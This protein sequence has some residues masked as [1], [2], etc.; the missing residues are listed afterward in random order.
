MKQA[1]NKHIRYLDDT[2]SFSSKHW[3]KFIFVSNYPITILKKNAFWYLP[4]VIW[5]LLEKKRGTMGTS[6][7][8]YTERC[9]R[10]LVQL[11]KKKKLAVHSYFYGIHTALTNSFC[12]MVCHSRAIN[13]FPHVLNHNNWNYSTHREMLS[14]ALIYLSHNFCICQQQWKR[15]I[16]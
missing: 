3:C 9:K 7:I 2:R 14:W 8:G 16:F 4:W 1:E 13:H 12:L 5:I 15:K 6:F 10:N 11:I